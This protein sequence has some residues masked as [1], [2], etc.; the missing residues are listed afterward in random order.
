MKQ[1]PS[2][3]VSPPTRD[4]P[5]WTAS[6]VTR[7][8]ELNRNGVVSAATILRYCEHMRWESIKRDSGLTRMFFERDHY[9][10]VRA[11]EAEILNPPGFEVPLTLR[12]WLG[13][14]GRTSLVFAQEVLERGTGEPVARVRV[15]AV[16]LG[17]DG[18]PAPVPETWRQAAP[19]AAARRAAWPSPSEAEAHRH[20]VSVRLADVDLLRHVNHAAYVDIAEDAA[21]RA[22]T[23]YWFQ[24]NADAMPACHIRHLVVDYEDQAVFGDTLEVF[25]WLENDGCRGSPCVEGCGWLTHIVRRRDGRRLCRVKALTGA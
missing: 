15:T 17:R 9:L 16:H 11:Q 2:P 23:A 10:V 14:V 24:A 22:M 4:Q 21:V 13:G 19:E 3:I 6:I 7:G 18:R 25:T 1:V 8:Y 5:V 20:V 12:L